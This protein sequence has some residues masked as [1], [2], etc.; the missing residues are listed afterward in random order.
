MAAYD[1]GNALIHGLPTGTAHAACRRSPCRL[2][3]SL[4]GSPVATWAALH[5][6]QFTI[7]NSQVTDAQGAECSEGD[8]LHLSRRE[9]RVGLVIWP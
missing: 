1:W 7:Y 2:A 6:L 5:N 4:A 9:V 3:D 8:G